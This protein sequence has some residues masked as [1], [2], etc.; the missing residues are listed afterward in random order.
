M[1]ISKPGGRGGTIHSWETGECGNPNGRPRKLASKMKH[2]GYKNSQIRDTLQNIA[3]LKLEELESFMEDKDA[4]VLELGVAKTFVNFL[5]KGDTTALNYI[6]DPKQSSGKDDA[7]DANKPL[8][9]NDEDA[10]K[11]Y[12][13]LI[14]KT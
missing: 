5:K 2:E 9:I 12:F 10:G 8:S 1:A 4:T 7:P 13:D 14:T 11:E 3:S 6:Y